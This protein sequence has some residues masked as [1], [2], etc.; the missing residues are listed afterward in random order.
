MAGSLVGAAVAFLVISVAG[1]L[2]VLIVFFVLLG[3]SGSIVD[4]G[5][6]ALLVWTRGAGVGPMI[7]ALHFMFAVGALACPLLVN[8]SLAWTGGL[9]PAAWVAAGAA[10]ARGGGPAAPGRACARMRTRRRRVGRRRRD[11][12]CS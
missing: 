11:A 3:L 1:S 5:G 8:R 2:A 9:G 6:N 7:N 10:A 4:V 12:C